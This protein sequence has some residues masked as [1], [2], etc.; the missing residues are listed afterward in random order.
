MKKYNI[1]ILG[2]TGLVGSTFLKVLEES[3]FLINELRLFA[4]EKSKG[5]KVVFKTKEYTIQT[6]QEG[7]FKGIDYALF[8][9]GANVSKQ[10]AAQAIKEGAIVIDNSSAF[11]MDPKIPLVV[12]E[13]NLEDA[14][15]EKLI[16]NPNCST[17][18]SVIPLSILDKEYGVLEVEYNTYQAVSG[19]G[20]KGIKA[21]KDGSNYPYDIRKT[22]IPHI[23]VFNSD[24]YTKEEQKMI[25]ET[26]KILHNQDLLVSA[27][28]VRVPVLN[29]H[30]VS[31]R[32]KL[33]KNP[34]VNEIKAIFANSDKVIL[35]DN[36]EQMIYPT[37]IQ[38]NNTDL[39]YVGRIRQDKIDASSILLYCVADNIRKGAA[40]NAIQIMKGLIN[41][42]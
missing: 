15:Q 28:C 38:A 35:L 30:A 25:D 17:I 22:C 12:P 33:R 36:P 32:V 29:C 40:S 39:V 13:V 5:K 26:K 23:D 21:L 6:V 7:A 2:A 20:Y 14:F 37:S 10:V 41:N 27:T 9:A 8:S 3:D 16:A 18:Q 4:S 11:R 19:S 24:G 42:A 1:A 34:G 31:M